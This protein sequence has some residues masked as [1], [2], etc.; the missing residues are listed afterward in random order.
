MPEASK[1]NLQYFESTS[2]RGLYETM[3]E[4]QRESNRR[5]S[6]VSIQH[7]GGMYC[8]IAL[9]GPVETTLVSADGKRR[10]IV[11]E[12][13]RLFVYASDYS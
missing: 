8:A 1:R 9:A 7:D 4:W 5:L 2:M 13:G 6:S 3:S 11:S 10:A 12:N